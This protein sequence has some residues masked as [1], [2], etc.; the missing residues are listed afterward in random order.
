MQPEYRNHRFFRRSLAGRPIPR[1]RPVPRML[2]PEPKRGASAAS[3]ALRL[4]FG[5]A[6]IAVVLALSGVGSAYGA[7]AQLSESLAPRLAQIKQ[8]DSFQ[9]TRIY[10]R[11]G[12]LLYEF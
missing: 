1:H 8:H 4:M 9:T 6:V 7:Y 10:D 11:N 12:T 3:W 5:L 2:R